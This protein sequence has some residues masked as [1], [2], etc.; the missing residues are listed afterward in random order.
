MSNDRIP[1]IVLLGISEVAMLLFL[2]KALVMNIARINT[3][4]LIT[5]IMSNVNEDILENKYKDCITKNKTVAVID[6]A[7]DAFSFI[8][9]NPF[10][11]IIEHK[12]H[13]IV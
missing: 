10:L 2:F 6:V 3:A 1:V 9:I 12:L 11:K 4:V 13:V 8:F 7:I 5:R